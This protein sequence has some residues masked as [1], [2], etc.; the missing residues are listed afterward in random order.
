MSIPELKLEIIKKVISISDGL[1]LEEIIRLINQE[2]A[3]ANTYQL[4]DE[5][6]VALKEGLQDVEDGNLY[7]SESA[8][9]MLEE[10]LK[11]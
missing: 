8:E 3:L 5:E 2:S 6:Q 1:I 11:K 9:K 7:S 10:W 4:T